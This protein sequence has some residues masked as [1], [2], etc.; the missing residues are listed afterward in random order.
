MV[1][2]EIKLENT[3]TSAQY[4]TPALDIHFIDLAIDSLGCFLETLALGRVSIPMNAFVDL[5][6]RI[7]PS[8]GFL[9]ILYEF[10]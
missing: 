6:V 5:S 2:G 1:N 10:E 7:Y 8:D 9:S 3:A 4:Q